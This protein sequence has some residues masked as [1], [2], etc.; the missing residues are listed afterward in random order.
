[1]FKYDETT[2]DFFDDLRKFFKNIYHVI[3]GYSQISCTII[4]KNINDRAY[5]NIYRNR[6][7]TRN[8]RIPEL[9][10]TPNY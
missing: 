6:R 8:T 4:M 1:M 3:V 7:R 5:V 9:A 2:L 10:P